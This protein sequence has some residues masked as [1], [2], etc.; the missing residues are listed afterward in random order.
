MADFRKMAETP[1]Q[2]KQRKKMEM[3]HSEEKR[4]NQA[5]K[6]NNIEHDNTFPYISKMVQHEEPMKGPS[7]I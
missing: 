6:E 2:A 3:K 4:K 7:I 5:R 1:E